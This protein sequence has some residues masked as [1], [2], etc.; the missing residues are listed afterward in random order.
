MLR[1]SARFKHAP[2][3]LIGQRQALSAPRLLRFLSFSESK[4]LAGLTLGRRGEVRVV[5]D[6]TSESSAALLV[7]LKRAAAP[8]SHLEP[9]ARRVS[10]WA[11]C[12]SDVLQRAEQGRVQLGSLRRGFPQRRKED[13]FPSASKCLGR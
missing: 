13:K 1:G 9:S 7:S 5:E 3:G 6:G 12:C 2:P 4:Q 10:K 11:S 8:C